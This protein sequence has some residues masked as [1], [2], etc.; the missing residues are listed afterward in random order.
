[1]IISNHVVS[2]KVKSECQMEKEP[3]LTHIVRFPKNLEIFT[4]FELST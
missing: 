2:E 3:Y 4:K 1:M